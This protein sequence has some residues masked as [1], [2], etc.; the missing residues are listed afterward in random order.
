M[1]IGCLLLWLYFNIAPPGKLMFDE[2][3]VFGLLAM[4]L[5]LVVRAVARGGLIRIARA[6]RVLLVGEGEITAALIRKMRSHPEYGLNPVGFVLSNPGCGSTRELPVLGDLDQLPNVLDG[7]A[8]DRIVVSPEQIDPHQL[9]DLLY[10]CKEL[11][12][13]VS[14]L[15]SVSDAMGP[16]TEIDDVEGVTVLGLNPPVLGRSSR[17]M[18]RALDV[19]GAGFALLITAPLAAVIALVIKLDSR[20][21][22]LF[23]QQRVGKE[24]RRFELVKFRTMVADAEQRG[25]ELVPQSSDPHWLKLDRDPRVTRVGRY[26]R[27]SSLD[28]LPQLWNVLRGEMS[29]VGPRPLVESEDELV[30]GWA[31]GRLDLTPGITGYWQVLGRTIIPFAEMVKLDYLYVTN[32]SLWTDIRLILRTL[33]AVITGRGAN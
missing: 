29:L 17:F 7:Q 16:S 21:S 25:A 33:P 24:G 28:E 8:I 30:E 13:K 32:W 11:S 6:E 5:T 27:R 10:R 4:S 26:L 19:A 31:R 2:I 3:L 20:G 12:R 9:M 1:L 23:R 18:K 22:V 15:P 14:L